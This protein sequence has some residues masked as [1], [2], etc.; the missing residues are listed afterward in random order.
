MHCNTV[1][2]NK[3]YFSFFTLYRECN[4]RMDVFQVTND[5]YAGIFLRLYVIWCEQNKTVMDSGYVIKG[6]ALYY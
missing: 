2:I 1:D 6:N 4:R 5:F 3:I